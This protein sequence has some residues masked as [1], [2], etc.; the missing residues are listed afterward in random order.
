MTRWLITLT[1]ALLLP[2]TNGFQVGG[3]PPNWK[4]T[5]TRSKKPQSDVS[6]QTETPKATVPLRRAT[7]HKSWGVD[8]DHSNEY[9]FDKRIH[10]LGNVGLGG[11]LHA[12]VAPLS[13]KLIDFLAYDGVDLRGKVSE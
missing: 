4:P 9:W 1:A 5:S 10:T 6:A 12:A 8:K 2:C 3:D 7:E 11:G 13:T